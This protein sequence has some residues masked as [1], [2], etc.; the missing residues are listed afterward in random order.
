MMQ[1]PQEIADVVADIITA[2]LLRI[3]A[4]DWRER[5]DRC[6]VEADHVHNLPNLLVDYSPELLD[7]YWST[8]RVCFI[9]NSSAEDTEGF[10]PAWETLGDIMNAARNEVASGRE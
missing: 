8:E 7:Y 1:C 2:A 5:P 4:T 6:V 3:R 10:I 9:N